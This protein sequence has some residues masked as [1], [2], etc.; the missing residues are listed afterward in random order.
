MQNIHMIYLPLGGRGVEES[1]RTDNVKTKV[2]M[3]TTIA[4]IP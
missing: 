2:T 3:G 4:F 1:V